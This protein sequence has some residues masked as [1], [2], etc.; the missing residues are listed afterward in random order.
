MSGARSRLRG[1]FVIDV[2]ELKADPDQPR[3]RFPHEAIDAMAASIEARGFQQPLKVRPAP[4]G[5]GYYI[6]DGEMRYRSAL[7]LG[8]Q[9]VPCWVF[10]DETDPRDI[11]LDQIVANEQRVN[12]QPYEVAQAVVR[13]R[14]H[15]EMAPE[16]ISRETGFSAPKISKLIALV[17]K[18]APDVQAMVRDLPPGDL[19]MNHLY[20]LSKLP[21]VKQP[22]LAKLVVDEHLSA[23]ETEMI[24]RRKNA[25]AKSPK[26]GGRPRKRFFYPTDYGEVVISLKE[27]PGD[28][29]ERQLKALAQAKRQLLGSDGA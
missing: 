8:R 2:R 4:D 10:E 6:I 14:D 18:V 22:G 7:Q 21:P 16:A 11:F 12:F 25:A 15:F 17:E 20:S 19:T 1:A 5:G 29:K 3:Q 23:S 24:V 26:Q 9:E 13:L 27:Q 28:L